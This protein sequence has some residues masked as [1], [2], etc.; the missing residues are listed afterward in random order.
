MTGQQQDTTAAYQWAV[1]WVVML[2]TFMSVLDSSIVNVSLPTMMGD[3]G[4][5][6]D[7]I[8]WVA[9]GYML[10]FAALMPLTGWLRDHIGGKRLYTISLAVFVL[11][12]IACGLSW[13][14]PSII[15]ARVFQALGGGAIV[16]T[17][18]AMISEVFPPRE[19]GKAMGIWG[20][21]LLVAPA[22]GPTLGGWMTHHL[23]WRSIFWVNLPVGAVGL[24]MAMAMLKADTPHPDGRRGFDLWGFVFFT[25]FL[26][27]F[28]LGLTNGESKGW[29]STYTYTCWG[30][31]IFGLAAFLLT[32]ALVKDQIID[33]SLFKSPVFSICI[34]VTVV[35]S[36][37]LF[38]G[39]FLLPVFVQRVQG[40]D[41][42]DAGLLMLPGSV[43]MAVIMPFSGRMSDK[44][45]A[46]WP[47]VAGM[48]SLGLFMWL[49]H[50]IDVNTSRWGIIMP[51][52]VRSVGMPLLMAPIMAAL[53]NAV[54]TRKAAQASSINAIAQQVGGSLGISFLISVLSQR[55]HFHIAAMSE[56]MS[57]SSPALRQSVA[58]IAQRAHDLG[59]THAQS[60]A[61]A[62]GAL[63]GHVAQSASVA[64]FQDAFIVATV[65]VLVALVTTFFLPDKPAHHA[66]S[67]E[68]IME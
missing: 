65:I 18:M 47:A 64:G 52:L 61:V 15:S 3:F 11:G 34:L 1:L 57:S 32:E 26:T 63:A 59:L 5:D 31:S 50:D 6:V 21:G 12:S 7:D 22:L 51:T 40:L 13:N 24:L 38:G 25:A 14:M 23:G 46:R 68:V 41:A 9:T 44:V 60:Q 10:A 37:A 19:R 27:A 29:H 36:V 20:M 17:G 42:V 66:A 33:L 67:V 30:I 28:L 54:P 58:G 53:L 35:R 48:V 45:G 2:G 43:L 55:T 56:V 4:V 8:E 39:V 62:G 49:Y 16:P